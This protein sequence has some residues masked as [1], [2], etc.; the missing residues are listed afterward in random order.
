MRKKWGRAACAVF[1]RAVLKNC[2]GG[3]RKEHNDLRK[4]RDAYQKRVAE[5]STAKIF[6]EKNSVAVDR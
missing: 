4:K 6:H 3:G 2:R 1:G 5:K